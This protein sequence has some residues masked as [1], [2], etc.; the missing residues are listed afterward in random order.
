MMKKKSIIFD[1]EGVLIDT[2][3]LW[4]LETKELLSRRNIIYNRDEVKHL[5]SGHALIEGVTRLKEFYNLS[6][7]NNM[8]VEE[9]YEIMAGLIRKQV[10]YFDG[11]IELVN[12][13]KKSYQLAVAT[14]M[15]SRLLEIADKKLA[16]KELFEDRVYS[17]SDVNNISKHKPD[18]FNYVLNKLAIEPDE[19]L[20]IED[21]PSPIEGAHL[22]GIE[23]VAVTT[24]Y[25]KDKL[26]GADYVLKH[27]TD[28][29]ELLT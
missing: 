15:D 9:R 14:A 16:L 24:T 6:D 26:T 13:L 12:K 8:L 19:A 1:L 2:E 11:V 27:V 21:S 20:I 29:P 3:R 28:L 22:A 25:S 4:D 7:A 17:V 10:G 18:L 5:L 23:V